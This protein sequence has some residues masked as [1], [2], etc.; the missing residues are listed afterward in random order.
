VTRSAMV[1]R[2]QLDQRSRAA[3]IGLVSLEQVGRR[4]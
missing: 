3:H 1:C 4:G 2:R